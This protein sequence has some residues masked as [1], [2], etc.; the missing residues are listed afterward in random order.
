LYACRWRLLRKICNV[1]MLGP[2]ALQSW[3]EVRHSEMAHMVRSMHA[4][5]QSREPVKL[6]EMLSAL[7]ANL[8][9]QVVLSRR[10]FDGANAEAAE[11]K[12]MV[13]ELF[14]EG[15]RFNIGDYIPALTWL[16]MQGMEKRMKA[17]QTRFDE[18]LTAMIRDHEMSAHERKGRPDLLD[19]ATAHMHEETR[20]GVRLTHVNIKGLLLVSSLISTSSASDVCF[21]A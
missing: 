4:S 6:I 16:D 1:H 2:Q 9:G 18:M 15:G 19:I 5:S 17:L 14:K 10:V 11:F 12:A 20:D 8:I 21:V 3:S 13:V 7:M